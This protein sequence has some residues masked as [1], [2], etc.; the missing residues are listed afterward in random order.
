[1]GAMTP[2]HKLGRWHAERAF[3]DSGY[4]LELLVEAPLGFWV[5]FLYFKRHPARH[6]VEV[7]AVAVQMAGTV[8]YYAPP[9]MRGESV[10]SWVSYCDRSFGSVWIIFP[11]IVLRRHFLEAGKGS[12]ADV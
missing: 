10:N 4:L 12:S 8:C 7:F 5:L 6:L 3:V 9:L 2:S 1:M 11:L